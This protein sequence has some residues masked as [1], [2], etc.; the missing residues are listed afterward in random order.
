M[1]KHVITVDQLAYIKGSTP[2]VTSAALET[3]L[4]RKKRMVLRIQ[5][6]PRLTELKKAKPIRD[7]RKAVADLD[8]TSGEISKTFTIRVRQGESHHY[9]LNADWLKEYASQLKL[10]LLN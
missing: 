10:L 5:E 1:F 4:D 7:Q 9:E 8:D 6:P 3:T 2:H